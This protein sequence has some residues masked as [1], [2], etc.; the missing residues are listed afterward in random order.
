MAL[1][2]TEMPRVF[3]FGEMELDDLGPA[4]TPEQVK[5][6]YATHYPELTSGSVSGPTIENGKMIYSLSGKVGTKG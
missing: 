1:N 5:D 3:K 4:F 6:H 2:V